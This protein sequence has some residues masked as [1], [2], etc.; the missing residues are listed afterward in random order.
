MKRILSLLVLAASALSGDAATRTE[1]FVFDFD[2]DAV[3]YLA[4]EDGT[5]LPRLAGTELP[6][7]NPGK[8]WLPVKDVSIRLPAGFAA[9]G[10]SVS[11]TWRVLRT[12]VDVAPEQEAHP[13]DLDA[14]QVARTPKNPAAYVSADPRPAA[15][16]EFTG[17]HR[18]R[19]LPFATVR[20]HPFSYVAADRTLSLA[21]SLEV[22]VEMDDGASAPAPA[23]GGG[24]EGNPAPEAAPADGVFDAPDPGGRFS[25]ALDAMSVNPLPRAPEADSSG[26]DSVPTAGSCTYLVITSEGLSR[27]VQRLVDYRAEKDGV[28]GGIVTVETIDSAYDGARPDGGSDRQTKIRNCIKD[29]VRNRGTE[30]VCLVGDNTI[31]PDR[32]TYVS[33]SGYTHDDM[34]TDLYYSDLDGTWDGDRD[35]VYGET[36]DGV[37]LAPDVVV[38]RIP[39]R[40]A[41][42]AVDY[43]SKL[44]A[45][46]EGAADD[47]WR[48]SKFLLGGAMTQNNVGSSSNGWPR[49]TETFNDGLPPYDGRRTV[50]SDVEVWGR[51]CWR[52]WFAKEEFGFVPWFFY[53]TITSADSSTE[54]DYA[55]TSA[56]M[57]AQ[58]SRGFQFHFW[59]AHG[60]ETGFAI[61]GA[62]NQFSTGNAAKLSD[63][64]AFQYTCACLTGAFDER[65]YDPCLSEAFLRD[66][67]GGSIGYL[68]CSREGWGSYISSSTYGGDSPEFGRAFYAKI[69]DEGV[70]RFGDAVAQSK[71]SRIGSASSGTGRWLMFGLNAQ[72]D[73]LARIF[74][75]SETRPSV[76]TPSVSVSGSSATLSAN[77]SSIGTAIA[78]SAVAWFEVSVGD[79]SFASPSVV[80]AGSLSGAGTV[81]A[82]ATGLASGTVYAR[83]RVLNEAGVEAVSAPGSSSGAVSR[84]YDAGHPAVRVERI[85]PVS[86]D[87]TATV[88]AEVGGTG[89]TVT[90]EWSESPSFA[91]ARTLPLGTV[92]RGMSAE[93]TVSGLSRGAF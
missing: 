91:N 92:A 38:G 23:A 62:I 8:P 6:S 87:G 9:T 4:L 42:Q 11:A 86:A 36:N 53:D 19:G 81:S 80:A 83:C 43:L 69:L 63:L 49:A 76:G 55:Q 37:D 93:G 59:F 79:P 72:G 44:F 45:Y 84:T 47:S 40:T 75:P 64:V 52:D 16:A 88:R 12:D 65:S 2:P 20:L 34:P 39:V 13:T 85:G 56:N 3:A 26:G 89:G 1:T 10:V 32:D 58:W 46:E 82:V 48:L 61:E 18:M 70:G 77:V 71:A 31:V 66:P 67:D 15:A 28:T 24:G 29:Y 5:E 60:Q 33:A 22:A 17:S 7:G 51:R 27:V 41:Q 68:G 50:A 57:V 78:G 25:A 73:P 14:S 74:P 21:T 30:Y 35:G 90:V 54:G